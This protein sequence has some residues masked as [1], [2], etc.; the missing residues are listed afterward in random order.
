MRINDWYVGVVEDIN[1]PQGQGRVRVRCLGY[2]TPDRN[3]LPTQDL[4]L[5]TVMLP[6]T[7]ASVA[8]IGLSA[9][10]LI[11]NTWVFGF[12][13]DGAELQDP[14]IM[15]T[16]ASASGY[17]VG[18]DVTGNIGF[19]DPHGVLDGFIGND[20]PPEAGTATSTTAGTVANSYGAAN[21]VNG[22]YMN[23]NGLS[24]SFDQPQAQFVP[25]GGMINAVNVARSQ[26][27][28][29]EQPPGSNN[30][31]DIKKF[32]SA[33]NNPSAYGGP[34]GFW[35]A[36][37]MCW[38]VQQSGVLTEEERPKS[39]R[40]FEW[41]TWARGKPY[42]QLRLS[43]RYIRAGDIFICSSSHIGIATTDSDANGSFGTI[44][45][46]TSGEG[47]RNGWGVFERKRNLNNG[48]KSAITIIKTASTIAV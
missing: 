12:F 27:Y 7:S 38:C 17:D 22:S 9:T 6:T 48:I 2:H 32:W 5:A 30:G 25:N 8:G 18:Y 29:R 31:A 34:K 21:A 24:T 42:A 10:A 1:D 45:G 43:P 36:A 39:A 19:G 41:E 4:P 15:G 14:V 26:L 46:N 35:C 11:P 37:F 44:E 16:I 47:I 3:K 13:R 40:C 23:S 28:V 20:I 33:T